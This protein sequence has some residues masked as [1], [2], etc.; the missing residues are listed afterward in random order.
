MARC[1]DY[2]ETLNL[3][4]IVQGDSFFPHTLPPRLDTDD[5][6]IVPVS[7]C[8]NLV[9]SFGRHVH[10]WQPLIAPSGEVTLPEILS[11]NHIR[12][13]TYTYSARYTM[14]DGLVRV[15]YRGEFILRPSISK[16]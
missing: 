6:P 8:V 16:C 15:F 12:Q 5:Q 1:P 10:S 9:D 2:A 7:V 11:T 3:E 13:G 4:T 14:A